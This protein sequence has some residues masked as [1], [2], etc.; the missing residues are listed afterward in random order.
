MVSLVYDWIIRDG[1]EVKGGFMDWIKKSLKGGKASCF[2]VIVISGVR[3]Y[4][5]WENWI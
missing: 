3:E 4:G 1:R 2:V 5:G